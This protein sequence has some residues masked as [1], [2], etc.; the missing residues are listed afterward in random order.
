[1]RKIILVIVFIFSCYSIYS[2]VKYPDISKM[3]QGTTEGN[4]YL[5]GLST[6]IIGN[7]LKVN[8]DNLSDGSTYQN[9]LFSSIEDSTSRIGSS[10]LFFGYYYENEFKTD[11]N[12][13]FSFFKLMVS[14]FK[15]KNLFSVDVLPIVS[16]GV[17]LNSSTEQIKDINYLMTNGL[18]GYGLDKFEFAH[19][20][21]MKSFIDNLWVS[22]SEELV[23][24][25]WLLQETNIHVS[26]ISFGLIH[27]F[28]LLNEDDIGQEELIDTSL[29]VLMTTALGYYL[30]HIT[31]KND[32][33]IEKAISVHYWFNT[34]TYF[35]HVL[36]SPGRVSRN[37]QSSCV[38][39]ALTIPLI[40]MSF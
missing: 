40:N 11:E 37:T 19:T 21:I 34:L 17:V 2:E 38:N 35:L 29:Q 13:S 6:F 24:R 23:F 4:Y 9:L 39:G 5:A 27:A 14:P 12:T 22:L 25:Y 33:N 3:L 20:L 1:M 8:H 15:P 30:G 18:S 26:S 36:S 28:N 10:L 16:L 31:L 32:Y 7:I